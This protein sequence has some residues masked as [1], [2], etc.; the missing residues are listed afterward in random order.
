MMVLAFQLASAERRAL[1]PG[2]QESPQAPAAM[3]QT[4]APTSPSRLQAGC[5][6]LVSGGLQPRLANATCMRDSW[7]PQC[8]YEAYLL[9]YRSTAQP[10]P[11]CRPWTTADSTKDSCVQLSFVMPL[12]RGAPVCFSTLRTAARPRRYWRVR[13]ARQP[14]VQSGVRRFLLWWKRV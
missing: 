14:D 7:N 3:S 6:R 10:T 13:Y 9:N 2:A 12:F 4:K 11:R 5:C 8:W 1:R